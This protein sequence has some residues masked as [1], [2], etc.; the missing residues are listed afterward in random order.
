MNLISRSS[1]QNVLRDRPLLIQTPIVGLI[2]QM[3]SIP[4]FF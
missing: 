2:F 4:V 3:N 1:H